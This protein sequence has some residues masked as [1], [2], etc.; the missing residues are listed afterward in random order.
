MKINDAYVA[1]PLEVERLPLQTLSLS[2]R[3]REKRRRIDRIDFHSSQ[4]GKPTNLQNSAVLR[5]L[6]EEEHRR[7][8]T[9]GNEVYYPRPLRDVSWPP[10]EHEQQIQ[11]SSFKDVVTPGSKRVAWPPPQEGILDPADVTQQSAAETQ[12]GA[13]Q[14]Y[15][16]SPGLQYQ[17]NSAPQQGAPYQQPA[18][19]QS[20][21]PL[22]PLDV[23]S[24]SA[25]SPLTSPAL[26]Q[27][28]QGF[29]P[30]TP[31]KGWAPVQSPLGAGAQK[32]F[33][34]TPAQSY[35]SQPPYQQASQPWQQ[36]GYQTPGQYQQP[37]TNQPYQQP[38][39]GYQTPGQYQQSGYQVP[40]HQYQPGG[41]QYQPGGQQYQPQ[42]PSQQQFNQSQQ[43]SPY[44]SQPVAQANQYQSSPS[45]NQFSSQPKPTVA[46]TQVA[47]SRP[48]SAKPVEP[49]P[50]TI[51]LRQTAPVSQA[52]APVFSAQP[53][54]ASLKVTVGGKHLRGDLKWPPDNVR[55]RMA[56]EERHLVELSKGPACRPLKKDKDYTPF[57]D[58]HALNHA[59]PGYKIPP[60]TQ[61]YRPEY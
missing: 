39:Q 22:K 43:Q 18:S 20:Y 34:A 33:G 48:Q 10:P 16:R 4:A 52:P 14:Y 35:S 55:Q 15:T 29:R 36:Q 44:Q 26:N 9:P 2:Q 50:S 21:R 24:V 8:V 11:R 3:S 28:P 47:A 38:G 56:D 51:T 42:Q 41:Q 57:F 54:T 7:G 53:A 60:G 46:Q 32:Y 6:E 12:G 17:S 13:P 23:S 37:G 61:F 27:S 40:G 1:T 45:Q 30:A 19:Q 5:M 59:Y 31:G 58:A 49:P 25:G